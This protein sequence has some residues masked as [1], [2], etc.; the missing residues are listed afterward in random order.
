MSGDIL[1]MQS[2]WTLIDTLRGGVESMRAAGETYLPR[3]AAEDTVDYQARLKYAA[4]SDIFSDTINSVASRPFSKKIIVEEY[5]VELETA[6][7]NVDGTGADITGFA[8]E[9]FEAGTSYG[10]DFILVEMPELKSGEAANLQAFRQSGA[11]PYLVPIK[12]SDLICIKTSFSGGE[13]VFTEFRYR[14]DY[15]D[16]S[17]NAVQ[18]VRAIYRDQILDKDGKIVGFDAP[19]FEV[20][21]KSGDAWSLTESDGLGIPEIPVVPFLTGRRVGD[22]WQVRPPMRGAAEMQVEHYQQE[23]QIKY[24]VTQT[25]FAMYVAMGVD[26]PIDPKT[27]KPAKVKVGPGMFVFLGAGGEGGAPDLKIIQPETSS[28]EFMQKRMQETEAQIRE[29]GKQ[30]LTAG[31][32]NITVIAASFASQK[33]NSA[34]QQWAMNL[35]G[36]LERAV[37]L[38]AMWMGAA[39]AKP[40]VTVH[41]D[42]AVLSQDDKSMEWVDKA[43][44]RDDIS[45]E[46]WA[47]EA[48]RRGHLE[49]DYDYHNDVG[50][51]KRENRDD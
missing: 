16:E 38:M 33:A 17:G 7:D 4:F 46:Q 43:R 45:G 12:A 34:A 39:D 11:R 50:F 14:A 18:C 36:S 24:A 28:L 26:Q 25:A 49:A 10:V 37:R 48:K 6:L 40:K 42:F 13:E 5:P 15:E 27:N 3:N 47:R 21:E 32:N 9:V 51:L 1:A 2:Y 23:N 22:G 30:P 31:S 29:L 8:S 20:C 19:Y 41:T 44:D 35:R